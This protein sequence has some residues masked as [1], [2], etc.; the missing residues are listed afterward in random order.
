MSELL[1]R[2]GI[3][4]LFDDCV[5]RTD[6]S[7]RDLPLIVLL[8]PHGSGKTW[9]LRYLLERCNR[10]VAVPFAFLDCA[11]GQADDVW[12]LVCD[13]ADELRG[14]WPE[15]GRLRFP[16][17]TLARLAVEPTLPREQDAAEEALRDVLRRRARLR[18]RGNA[19]GEVLVDAAQALDL[20]LGEAKLLGRLIA[21]VAAARYPVEA[22]YRGGLSWYAARGGRSR[23]GGLGELVRLNR[24]FHG[25]RDHG[26][27]D[28][29]ADR[30]DRD[31]GAK[32]RRDRDRGDTARAGRV[33]VEAFLADLVQAY[34]GANR[35][36]N[37]A[38]LLDGCDA[39][40]AGVFL[41]LVAETRAASA[42]RDPLVVV[43]ASG[44]V[45]VLPGLRERW[46]MPWADPDPARTVVP[47]PESATCATWTAA[48]GNRH[49][50]ESWLLPVHLRDLTPAELDRALTDRSSP[51]GA[52]S[53]QTR[54]FV[55]RLTA[56]HPWSAKRV[57]AALDAADA[58][59]DA[60]RAVLGRLSVDYLFGDLPPGQ[61]RTLVR[62]SA[63]RDVDVASQA[64]AGPGSG[65]SSSG[66]STALHDELERRLWLVRGSP[67]RGPRLHP[68]LRRVLLWRLAGAGQAEW[69][70]V[71]RR[72]AEHAMTRRRYLDAAY[73]RLACG[74]VRAAVDHLSKQFHELDAEHWI[75][76]FGELTSAPG[77]HNPAESPDERY[78][79]LMRERGP[80]DRDDPVRDA[81]WSM[82]AARWI[83][84]DPVGDPAST[85]VDA[86]ADGFARLAGKADT[87]IARY[88]HEAAEY[89]RNG[90]R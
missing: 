85:L 61:R 87:G 31:R 46:S 67:R 52:V 42:T 59:P 37:C 5:R 25:A 2:S 80:A 76:E 20:P 39:G 8:G 1:G 17:V 24:L 73:H 84:A 45:P 32:G 22:L 66:D 65:A 35:G 78:E 21:S 26:A 51:D 9:T 53:A 33:L 86:I 18:E 43:A 56:G 55:H 12:Q 81:L 15:F 83:W 23:G 62:W 3:V 88:R 69:G 54:G 71:H 77:R 38:V 57:L 16:R 89:R 64:T 82:V 40:P 58:S 7:T 11:D 14:P 6:R 30:G 74:D 48:R 90:Q 19:A 70:A 28:H 41:R 79:A 44:T 47:A 34:A 29:G 60:M 49:T 63:A 10:S 75:R 4:E 50:A 36:L 72:L 13:L 68:W 27:K